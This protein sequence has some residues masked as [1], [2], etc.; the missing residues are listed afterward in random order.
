LPKIGSRETPQREKKRQGGWKKKR[1]LEYTRMH[2]NLAGYQ[3]AKGG[4]R[5]KK[6]D[7]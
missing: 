6:K 7:G 2:L 4:S 5:D 1:G 3:K